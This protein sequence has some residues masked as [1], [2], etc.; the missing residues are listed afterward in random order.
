LATGEHQQPAACA[1]CLHFDHKQSGASAES[2]SLAQRQWRYMLEDSSAQPLQYQHTV[3]TEHL[4][5]R[6]IG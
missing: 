2:C 5:L 6:I 3:N 1:A 4:S